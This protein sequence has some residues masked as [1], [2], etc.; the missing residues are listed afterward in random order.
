MVEKQVSAE[1]MTEPRR[2]WE[3]LLE[4]ITHAGKWS[5]WLI[6]SAAAVV[7]A[8]LAWCYGARK[9]LVTELSAQRAA[10]EAGVRWSDA[11]AK[12]AELRARKAKSD[13]AAAAERAAAERA[14]RRSVE[15]S[16]RVKQTSGA[17]EMIGGNDAARAAAF[18]ARHGLRADPSSSNG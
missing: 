12:N 7:V 6:A 8:V 4:R 5:W 14:R 13:E 11:K 16:R 9:P 15:L 3:E 1:P 10:G 17:L 2:W 18:N